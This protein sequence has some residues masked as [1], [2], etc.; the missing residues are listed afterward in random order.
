MR[1]FTLCIFARAWICPGSESTTEAL[2]TQSCCLNFEAELWQA[3]WFGGAQPPQPMFVAHLTLLLARTLLFTALKFLY[4]P[5]FK[6]VLS[7]PIDKVVACVSTYYSTYS[8]H[9]KNFVAS[10]LRGVVPFAACPLTGAY[11][12]VCISCSRCPLRRGALC[13]VVPFAACPLTGAYALVGAR[14]MGL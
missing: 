4:P 10:C 14:D 6:N 7:R 1:R 12:L 2:G 3:G 8:V 11:A 13:G 9:S 5:F